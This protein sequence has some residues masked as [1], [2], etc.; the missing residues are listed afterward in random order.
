VATIESGSGVLYRQL[1]RE[2]IALTQQATEHTNRI[3][4][5]LA[6]CG[7]EIE[8]DRHFQRRLAELRQWDGTPLG[9]SLRHRLLREF[10]RLALV[11]RQIRQ[12][13]KSGPEPFAARSLSRPTRSGGS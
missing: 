10:E 6:T 11:R 5:L 13:N 8:V 3:K 7:L 4:S 12:P 2:L 9:D 1:H